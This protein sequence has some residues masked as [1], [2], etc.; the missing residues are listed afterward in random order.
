MSGIS[1]QLAQG[2]VLLDR[3]F[4]LTQHLIQTFGRSLSNLRKA[5]DEKRQ[6]INQVL[7][8]Y[9]YVFSLVDH[10]VR[11]QK[12]ANSLPRMNQKS[13]EYRALNGALSGLRDVRNQIQH[14]NN[15][16][17]NEFKRPLLGA[18]FWTSGNIQYAVSFHDLGRERSSPGIVFDTR[19]R[20]YAQEFCYVYNEVY[21]DLGKAIEGF[22][23][24]HRFITKTV[25]VEMDGKPYNAKEHFMAVKMGFT[26]PDEKG[27]Y[28]DIHEQ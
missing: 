24:F 28:V 9:N 22:R 16:I 11:Y 13:A 17:E 2:V 19:T 27:L 4:L 6:N 15:D 23:K 26:F 10:L 5:L 18:I 21:Y 8:V 7:S 20:T 1:V 3:Q 12:I 25:K 14:I